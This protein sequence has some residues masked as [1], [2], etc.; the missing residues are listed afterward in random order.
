MTRKFLIILLLSLPFALFAQTQKGYVRTAG[1][2]NES[3]KPLSGVSVKPSGNYNAALSDASGHFALS[4]SDL[5]NGD[6]FVLQDVYKSGY[7]LLDKE[8]LGYT[9]PFSDTV[10]LEIVMISRSELLQTQIDIEERARA[11]AEGKYHARLDALEQQLESQ[12]ISN[13]SY[14]EQLQE[15]RQQLDAFNALATVMAERYARTDYDRLDSLNRRINACIANGDFAQATTLINAKGNL[16]Q[17]LHDHFSQASTL[18]KAEQQLQ[19]AK[20][21]LS[22]R[23]KQAKLQEEELAQDL[24]NKSSIAIANFK[25]DSAALFMELRASLDTTNCNYQIDAANFISYYQGNYQSSVQYL[26][27]AERHAENESDISTIYNNLGVDLIELGE[28]IQALKYHLQALDILKETFGE[29]HPNVASSLSNIGSAY[30]AQGIYDKALEYHNK[31]LNIRME[32][33]GEKH[34]GVANSLGN[35]GYVYNSQGIYDKALEYY[36]KAL[37]IY[38]DVLGEKH[39]DVATLLNKIGGVYD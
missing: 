20:Q 27:R 1:K 31:A 22:L 25:I 8:F 29:K 19:Q 37:N 30:C 7:E 15:L 12:Q 18:Q 4:L 28:Y 36:N 6:P 9:H 17:R 10:S 26:R 39:P 24:Y 11:N 3:G 5:R 14:R 35:I 33:L 21:Q 2:P 13:E 23:Q 38:I 34:L 16:S 32:V